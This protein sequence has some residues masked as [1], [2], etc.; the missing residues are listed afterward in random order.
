MFRDW[1]KNIKKF[2]YLGIIKKFGNNSVLLFGLIFRLQSKF[3]GSK[4]KSFGYDFWSQNAKN[5]KKKSVPPARKDAWLLES[6]CRSIFFS[7]FGLQGANKGHNILGLDIEF[8]SFGTVTA[9][10][11]AVKFYIFMSNVNLNFIL[12]QS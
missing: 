12:S 11:F 3:E 2:V 10:G 1:S 6:F 8:F 4:N 7:F 5:A 9:I